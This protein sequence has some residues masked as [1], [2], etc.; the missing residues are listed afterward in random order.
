[1]SNLILLGNRRYEPADLR[2]R[3]QTETL[4]DKVL[5]KEGLDLLHAYRSIPD[6]HIR[7]SLKRLVEDTARVYAPKAKR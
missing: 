2:Q 4:V 5:V 1:M 6:E 7:L 3:L